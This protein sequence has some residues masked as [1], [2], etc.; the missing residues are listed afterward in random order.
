M[1]EGRPARRKLRPRA[2]TYLFR[3]EIREVRPL[4]VVRHVLARM[5]KR[6]REPTARMKR[7]VFMK[8]RSTAEQG[9]ERG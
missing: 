3:T 7:R 2:D 5:N 1:S 4:S 6:H 8:P 9:V